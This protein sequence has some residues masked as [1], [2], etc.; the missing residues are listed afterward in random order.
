MFRLLQELNTRPFAIYRAHFYR[1]FSGEVAAAIDRL[2]AIGFS[3]AST[4]TWGMDK[5]LRAL[6]NGLLRESWRFPSQPDH[7][8]LRLNIS[9]PFQTCV[10][11]RLREEDAPHVSMFNSAEYHQQHYRPIRRNG[12][13]GIV[14][15][16]LAPPPLRS[17]RR[18]SAPQ[19]F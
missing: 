19:P 5:G 15:L 9:T 3:N 18:V 16:H 17:T 14:P 13:V 11:L 7:E 12:Q 10:H 8:I 6:A 2:K 1:P 4:E